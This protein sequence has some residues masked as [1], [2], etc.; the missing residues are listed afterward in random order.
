MPTPSGREH[1]VQKF[2]PRLLPLEH[3]A[4][5]ACSSMLCKRPVVIL[6]IPAFRVRHGT[7][8]ARGS[9]S[10]PNIL[11]DT[12]PDTVPNNLSIPSVARLAS[13]Y[14]YAE[15]DNR[16]SGHNHSLFRTTIACDIVKSLPSLT[17]V[18]QCTTSRRRREGKSSCAQ[19]S[20]CSPNLT[21]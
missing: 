20:D 21:G 11:P 15:W 8:T 16:T 3:D 9:T 10:P 2:E 13:R 19:S 6:N 14:I 7:R 17:R 1:K 4:C 12:L 18:H 5:H